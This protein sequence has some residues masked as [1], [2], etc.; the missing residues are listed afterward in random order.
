MSMKT[1]CEIVG[2]DEFKG[3]LK[4]L[5]D[6]AAGKALERAA[7]AGALPIRNEA[8]RRAPKRTGTLRRSI[9]IETI[10]VKPKAALV[11]IGTDLEYAAIHEFGGVI[12]HPG[13]TPYIL[14]DSQ[15][16][17]VSKA[18]APAGAPVTAPHDIPVPAR[19]YLRPAFDT[20]KE[21]A[22]KEIG[23]VLKQILEAAL[24]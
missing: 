17:F 10:A 5:D 16:R 20:K 23:I 11:A 9:H 3:R 18:N 22:V 14:I 12:H 6:A 13:G 8:S 24:R 21:E 1:R 15:V 7:R 4:K 19:P 2:L